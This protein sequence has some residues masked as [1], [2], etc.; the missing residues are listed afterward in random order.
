MNVELSMPNG[1][2]R[3]ISIE[4]FGAMDGWDI[5]ERFV[6]FAASKD[7]V[8]RRE[9]TMEV[10][11]YA[12]VLTNDGG[13]LPL[14][15]DALIDNHLGS[16]ENI[17]DVF[18]EILRHNDID[19]KEHCHRANFWADAGSDMATSFVAAV[20]IAISNFVDKT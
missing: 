2:T 19:P 18:E 7:K 4:R 16:W 17:R 13:T 5:Q 14:T 8:M 1:Q 9:Y 10:L 6:R 11:R 20:S 15:T 3:R 12:K